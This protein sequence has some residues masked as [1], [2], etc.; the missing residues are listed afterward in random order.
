MLCKEKPAPLRK[1]RGPEPELGEK[2][3]IEA[4]RA[5]SAATDAPFELLLGLLLQPQLSGQ[6]QRRR[7]T[8]SGHK[9]IE[10][11]T[12]PQAFTKKH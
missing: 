9:R 2:G 5:G 10:Q 6:L 3:W 7:Q 4:G 8:H 1:L 12:H 11:R